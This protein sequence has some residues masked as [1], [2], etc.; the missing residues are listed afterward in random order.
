M[1]KSRALASTWCAPRG[2]QS[3]SGMGP[4]WVLCRQLWG[5]GEFA[6]APQAGVLAEASLD[7]RTVS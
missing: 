5:R 4:F 1:Q 7:C 2:E 6:T 3:P